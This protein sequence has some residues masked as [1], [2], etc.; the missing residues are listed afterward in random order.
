MLRISILLPALLAI[1]AANLPAQEISVH[2]GTQIPVELR[3]KLKTESA[4]VGAKIEFH[5]TEAVL[6]GH[7]IVVPENAVVT[8]RVESVVD[9]AADSPNSRLRISIDALKWKHG[10]A[11]LN[12]VIISVERSPAQEVMILRG[13]RSFRDPPTFLKNVHI[14][15]HLSRKAVTVFYSDRPSFTV[16]KGL[17]FLLRQVDPDHE[18]KMAGKDNIL[19][20]GPKD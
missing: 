3:T 8:G 10:E 18:P 16:P 7:N 6:I 15:A 1:F 2:P 14:R 11:S 4:R 9:G 13:R 5:T 20:V 12:A 17:N 19:Q